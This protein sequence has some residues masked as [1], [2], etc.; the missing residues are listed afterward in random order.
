MN[1]NLHSEKHDSPIL[2]NCEPSSNSSRF[3]VDDEKHDSPTDLTDLG[4]QIDPSED[5]AKQNDS[6]NRRCES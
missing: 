4:M 2:P 5:P 3:N 6:I 1:S